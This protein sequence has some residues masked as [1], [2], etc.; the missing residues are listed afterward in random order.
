MDEEKEGPSRKARSYL[1]YFQRSVFSKEY[2]EYALNDTTYILLKTADIPT[3]YRHTQLY[4]KYNTERSAIEG[5][6]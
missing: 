4:A 5:E 1:H 2:K 3:F 6:H